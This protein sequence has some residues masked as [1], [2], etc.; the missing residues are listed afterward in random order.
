MRNIFEIKGHQYIC[1][2]ADLDVLD[3]ME[4]VYTEPVEIDEMIFN[5]N[6]HLTPNFYH[7]IIVLC[8]VQK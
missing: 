8:L 3:V 2:D 7:H 1:G 6:S 5:K 4:N